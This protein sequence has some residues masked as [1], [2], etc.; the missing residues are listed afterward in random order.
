[1]EKMTIGQRIASRRKLLNLSQEA[2]A[3]QLCVSRQAVS[4]WES[5]GAIPEIDKLIQ[6]GRIFDVRVGWILGAEA[7]MDP[8]AG[9][10]EEQRQILQELMERTAPKKK[11]S[12]VAAGLCA[13]AAVAAVL[14]GIATVGGMIH[15]L[16]G[17]Q[18]EL[19]E[20]LEVIAQSGKQTEERMDAVNAMIEE[21][22]QE[23]KLLSEVDVQ[24]WLSDDMSELTATFYMTPRIHLEGYDAYLSIQNPISGY[25]ELIKCQWNGVQYWVRHTMPPEDGYRLDFMLVSDYG[26]QIENLNRYDPGLAMLK[27]YTAFHSQP[28]NAQNSAGWNG[29]SL[30]IPVPDPEPVQRSADERTYRFDQKLHTPHIFVK[31]ALA[32]KQI[33][34]ELRLNQD[35]LW[36]RSYL[37]EFEAILEGTANRINAAD[38]TV[39][40]Q[41]ELKL[42][43]LAVGDRLELVLTAQ[44]V[45]GN[46][47]GQS[48]YTVL[49]LQEI[50]E[51]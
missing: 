44:T 2:L 25:Q 11:W 7:E 4:K 31:T 15:R 49:D 5:D 29:T 51:G 50:V 9:I 16:R 30:V 35:V 33:T 41:I 8:D 6:L 32:Y 39:D 10:P 1:M 20:E 13:V 24:G 47:P 27:T 36:S 19:R 14:L 38:R 3:D 22:S 26:Y 12:R 23:Q 42:P 40:L 48:Y 21:M 34:V 43:Q 46:A 17:E 37:E 45:N 18:A 28:D